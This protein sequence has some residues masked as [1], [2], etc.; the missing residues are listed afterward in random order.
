M[1]SLR[2]SAVKSGKQYEYTYLQ[3][4]RINAC[5]LTTVREYDY[6]IGNEV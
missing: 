6:G 5:H 2:T 4:S 3:E 1:I